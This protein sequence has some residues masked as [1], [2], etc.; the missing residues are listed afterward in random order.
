MGP[1]VGSAKAMR[2]RKQACM[3]GQLGTGVPAF[4]PQVVDLQSP[5]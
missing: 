4:Y 5:A 1:K 2:H 3:R